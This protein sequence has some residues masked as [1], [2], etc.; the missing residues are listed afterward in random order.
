MKK[1]NYYLWAAIATTVVI[2]F[3]FLGVLLSDAHA[4]NGDPNGKW[5]TGMG[6]SYMKFKEKDNE[7]KLFAD[8]ELIWEDDNLKL[9]D[10]GAISLDFTQYYRINNLVSVG[11]EESYIFANDMK[12]EIFDVDAGF[13][14]DWFV[15]FELNVKLDLFKNEHWEIVTG[16]GLCT[17]YVKLDYEYQSDESDWL[18]G[19][20]VF[21][22]IGYEDQE[23]GLFAQLGYKYQVIETFEETEHTEILGYDFTLDYELDYSNSQIEFEIGYRLNLL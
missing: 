4:Q 8:G 15:Q 10:D 19:Y 17:N 11:L 3:V 13:E 1:H 2:L 18:N 14:V 23:T 12:Y 21:A 6:L 5:D 16:A 9:K 22:R 20:Q 7:Y